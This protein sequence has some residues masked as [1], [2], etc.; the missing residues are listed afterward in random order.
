MSLGL[1]KF[2]LTAHVTCSVGWLGAVGAFFALAIAGLTGH[3]AQMVR[4]AYLAMELT[5]WLVIVPLA[6]AALPSGL[7]MSLGTEWGLFR[8]YW[9]AAKLLITIVATIILLMHLQPIGHVASVVATT[10]LA[11]GEL[12]GLRMQ[13]VADA[14]A[15]L[16]ALLAATALSVYKPRGL[17]AYGRRRQREQLAGVRSE[18]ESTTG[19]PLW[20]KAAIVVVLALLALLVIRHL[21]GGPGGH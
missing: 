20:V 19:K 16:V 15:A 6:C 7:V 4:A 10:T 2:A 12:A 11:R 8:H 14:G 9:V 21:G 18:R 17:T 1:R 5:A 3:D 13:L